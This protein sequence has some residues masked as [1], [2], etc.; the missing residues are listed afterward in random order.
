M[1]SVT[2]VFK[3]YKEKKAAIEKIIKTGGRTVL[4]FSNSSDYRDQYIKFS[5]A[6][7]QVSSSKVK[8]ESIPFK[9]YPYKMGVKLVTTDEKWEPHVVPGGAGDLYGVCVNLDE[10]T[11]TAVV[12]PVENS[13]SFQALLVCKDNTI[14]I[15]DKLKFNDK[16]ELEKQSG[17]SPVHAYAMSD[18]HKI[19]DDLYIVEALFVGNKTA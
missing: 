11:G 17:A 10:Y 13:L 16:G 2:Q 19:T 5:N 8:L 4:A 18:A 15:K 14:K 9:D 7:F 1:A 6:N 12:V 3:E